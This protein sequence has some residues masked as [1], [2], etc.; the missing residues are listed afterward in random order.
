MGY[1]SEVR[2]VIHGPKEVILRE[3]ANLRLTG[4]KVMQE[5][6]DE[7][8]VMET[9]PIVYRS[10]EGVP[11]QVFPAAAAILGKGGTSWKWYVSYPDVQAHEHVFRHFQDLYNEHDT[12]EHP[13][14][15]LNG[16]FVRIGEDDNDIET[17]Y[18]GG[19]PNEADMELLKIDAPVTAPKETA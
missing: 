3:F 6:L 12:D 17:T 19:D 11:N 15:F 1:R 7:W 14:S 10:G 16:A 13:A 5:A 4:D 18:F 8:R 2:M 9:A